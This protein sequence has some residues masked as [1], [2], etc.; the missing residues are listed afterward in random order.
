MAKREFDI[1]VGDRVRSFDFA[2]G[3]HGRDLKGKNACYIE[4]VVESIGAK[5]E[6]FLRY[7]IRVTKDVF[8]GKEQS[9]RL[10]MLVYPPVNGT[11]TGL[12]GRTDSVELV[13]PEGGKS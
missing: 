7:T 1:V 3:K 2:M 9:D 11:P 6:G 13:W 8:G 10:G 4:G 12:G 5:V